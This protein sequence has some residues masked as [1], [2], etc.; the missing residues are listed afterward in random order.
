MGESRRPASRGYFRHEKDGTRFRRDFLGATTALSFRVCARLQWSNIPFV[1]QTRRPSF[2]T[3]GFL[4]IDNGPCHNLD[5]EG[6]AWLVA[7]RNRIELFRL[8]PYSPEFNPIEGVWKQAKKRTT[9]NVFYRTTDERDAALR[10]T[11][12][13]FQSCP[14]LIAPQVA[15]FLS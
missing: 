7:Q 10:A 14:P 6:K 13:H 12:E 9:R 15:R 8:P 1:P 5:D 4:I 11:F 2:S 3:Q